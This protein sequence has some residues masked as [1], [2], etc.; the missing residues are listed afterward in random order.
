MKTLSL[1]KRLYQ[2]SAPIY[3]AAFIIGF[4]VVQYF[5]KYEP[6]DALRGQ[7]LIWANIVSL[8]VWAFANVVL[9]LNSSRR[10]SRARQ[11][12]P[13][14]WYESAFTLA[15]IVA[16]LL[17]AFIDPVKL[18]QNPIYSTIYKGLIGAIY[19]GIES[20]AITYQVYNIWRRLVTAR[21]TPETL[22]IIVTF[23]LMGFRSI[24]LLTYSVPQTFII[25][26]WIEKVA[27]TT[28]TR[29][30]TIVSAVGTLILAIRALVGKEPGIIEMEMG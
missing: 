30:I 1:S 14:A 17:I 13:R 9:V 16:L 21:I 18:D 5:I 24:A 28:T 2:R 3:I 11:E 6:L 22:V 19:L 8:W 26:E 4:M 25:A 23:L 12:D 10:V 27:Y 15:T 7:T 20:T 29:A